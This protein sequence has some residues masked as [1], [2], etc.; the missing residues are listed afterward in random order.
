MMTQRMKLKTDRLH[1]VGGLVAL[2]A[3]ASDL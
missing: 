1:M 2:A 3:T